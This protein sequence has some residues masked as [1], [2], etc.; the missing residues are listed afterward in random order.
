MMSAFSFSIPFFHISSRDFLA[1]MI[2]TIGYS[3]KSQNLQVHSSWWC[4]PIGLILVTLGCCYWQASLLKFCWTD[5]VPFL[6]SAIAGTLMVFKIACLVNSK[7]N[8]LKRLLIY[9]GD[10]TLTILTW[11][12]L[13]F[14]LVSL[15]IIY[16]ENLPIERLAEFPVIN[17]YTSE[18]WFILYFI[19][20]MGVPLLFARMNQDWNTF[21]RKKCLK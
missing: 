12:F 15:I 1:A 14:K 16:V 10:N 17:D 9:I 7:D 8:R 3:Y 4:V 20:G 19:V 18:G 6:V 21:F 13:S 11:H 2:F 5:V